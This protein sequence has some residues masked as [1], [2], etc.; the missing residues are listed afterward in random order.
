MNNIDLKRLDL[1]KA[2]KLMAKA[3]KQ[4]KKLDNG[5]MEVDDEFAEEF[6]GFFDGIKDF[7]NDL[8]AE[9]ERLQAQ[10]KGNM[11]LVEAQANATGRKWKNK[12]KNIFKKKDGKEKSSDVSAVIDMQSGQKES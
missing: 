7:N 10:I 1:K 11:T 3:K 9:S 8:R 2:M 5:M 6:N 4:G 12:I